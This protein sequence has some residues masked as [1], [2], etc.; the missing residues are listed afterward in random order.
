VE[1]CK[2][3]VEKFCQNVQPGGG[4]I[5]QCLQQH[6]AELSDACKAQQHH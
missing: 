2:P 4:R 5:R 6:E 3:D 1:A